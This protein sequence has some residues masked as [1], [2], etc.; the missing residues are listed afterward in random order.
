MAGAKSMG[1]GT[2]IRL[3][4]R[5]VLIT[6]GSRGLG[7][8]MV[9]E[10]GADGANVLFCS[11]SEKQLVATCEEL[12]S[13]FPPPQKLV[14]QVCDI[15]REKEVAQLFKRLADEFRTLYAVINNA[16]VQGPIG[17]FDEAD[18][19]AWRRTIEINLV[20]TAL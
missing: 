6:G 14:A 5:N 20:G 9:K 11:Q 2:A 1:A 10:F 17:A 19:S 16:G 15:S 12:K 8:A 13:F 7:R 18:W 3:D 4:G